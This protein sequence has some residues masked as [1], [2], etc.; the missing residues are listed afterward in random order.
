M[1]GRI[2]NNYAGIKTNDTRKLTDDKKYQVYNNLAK[3]ISTYEKV[4]Y[5]NLNAT[6]NQHETAQTPR[7]TPDKSIRS[8]NQLGSIRQ[9]S[10]RLE[11]QKKK[12]IKSAR[13]K[14]QS[15]EIADRTNQH[16]CHT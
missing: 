7:I 11:E 6:P 9:R 13:K 3:D 14:L 2:I 8:E 16:S 4:K 1:T 10:P 15:E 5:G 12:E